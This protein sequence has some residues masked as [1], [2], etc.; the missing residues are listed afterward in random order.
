MSSLSERVGKRTGKVPSTVCFNDLTYDEMREYEA[1]WERRE[2][3][4]DATITVCLV[5]ESTN[6]CFFAM[7]M[8]QLPRIG[9]SIEFIDSDGISTCGLVANVLWTYDQR[10]F[11]IEEEVFI[12]IR[13]VRVTR[14]AKEQS[15]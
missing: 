5:N 4:A 11:A 15:A 6:N 8:K 2:T 14:L 9:D 13:I 12:F 1:E 10:P 7:E 3:Q